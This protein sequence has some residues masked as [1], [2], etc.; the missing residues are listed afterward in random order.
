MSVSL[1][2]GMGPLDLLARDS[3]PGPIRAES[4]IAYGQ[5]RP[6]KYLLEFIS[7]Q[8]VFAH[9]TI[10]RAGDKEAILTTGSV[11]A[12]SWFPS[13]TY[14]RDD[15]GIALLAVVYRDRLIV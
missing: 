15:C 9:G 11:T 14:T 3:N 13:H 12:N 6:D 2:K 8:R 10:L 7:I 1:V 5:C 4:Y